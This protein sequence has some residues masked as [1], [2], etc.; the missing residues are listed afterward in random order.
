MRAQ[1]E[2][3]RFP[4]QKLPV[5]KPLSQEIGAMTGV[6]VEALPNRLELHVP[7]SRKIKTTAATMSLL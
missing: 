1:A 2:V 5:V 4:H 6:F 7:T 3:S